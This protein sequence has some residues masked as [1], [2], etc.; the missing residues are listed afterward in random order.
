[1]WKLRGLGCRPARSAPIPRRGGASQRRIESPKQRRK[2]IQRGLL[3]L[4]LMEIPPHD[5]A[6]AS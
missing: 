4:I 5:A 1:V 6:T 2:K 3:G